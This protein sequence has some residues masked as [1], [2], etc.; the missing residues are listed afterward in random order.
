MFLFSG[1][2]F[3]IDAYPEP[4]RML[5][6]LTPLYQ[7][8]ELLRGLAVGL[9]QPGMLGNVLYLLAMGLVGLAIVSRRVGRLLLR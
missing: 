7:G 2:F 6:Q 4:L 3:P 1:T 5:V 9:V 8:V